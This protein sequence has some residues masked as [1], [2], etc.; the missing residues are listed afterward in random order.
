[1]LDFFDKTYS[2]FL[3]RSKFD[4]FMRF[5]I[6]RIVNFIFPY[7][8]KFS[9]NNIVELV[10]CDKEQ[11]IVSIT[12]FPSR[13]NTFWMVIEC[14]LRQSLLPNKI[15]LWLSE[16]QFPNKEDDLP[17]SLITYINRK[18]LDVRFVSEDLRSHKKYYYAMKFFPNDIII[19]LDD[20]I[21]YPSNIISDLVMLHKQYPKT[22]CCHRAHKV[23]HLNTGQLQEYASWEKIYNKRG[24]SF[25]M[26]HTS[27]GGTLYKKEMFTDEVLNKEVFKKLCFYADDVWLNI[28][29]HLSG[30]RTVKSNYFSHLIPIIDKG[31][32]YKLSTTNVSGGGNDLQLMNLIK[33]YKIKEYEIFN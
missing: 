15:I 17:N 22:I 10:E 19:T 9:K 31:N 11:I 18:I 8:L 26:F 6:R 20:D 1:M 14:V 30:T 2:S 23:L 29:A 32:T 13:I 5:I 16:N 27:G 12:S 24:P 33:H 3:K 7:Y 25:E 4:S 21:F 28:M